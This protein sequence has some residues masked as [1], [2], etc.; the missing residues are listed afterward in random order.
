MDCVQT[1]QQASVNKSKLNIIYTILVILYPL[2]SMYRFLGTMLS[3]ADACAIFV[4]ILMML[5]FFN[6]FAINK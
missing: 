5:R 4:I 6:T 2:F 3:I 1:M